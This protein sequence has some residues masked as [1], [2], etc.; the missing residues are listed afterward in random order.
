[1]KLEGNSNSVT[2]TDFLERLRERHDGL[3]HEIWHSDPAHR[4]EAVREYFRMPGVKLSLVNLPGYSP[5]FNADESVWG[6]VRGGSAAS[7]PAW[8]AAKLRSDGAA[9]R[10][11]SQGP[12][13]S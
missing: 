12:K 7:S 5:D 4:G 1:M 3:L 11:C 6:L 10:S 8:P 2:S 13:R 9:G